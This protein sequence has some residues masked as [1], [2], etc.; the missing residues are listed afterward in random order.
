MRKTLTAT[1]A[2]AAAIPLTFL[3]ATPASAAPGDISAVFT[4][5]PNP[6]GSNTVTGTFTATGDDTIP[7]TCTM[8]DGGAFGAN[9]QYLLIANTYD[10]DSLTR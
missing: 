3:A 10:V 7:Y 8:F 6:G 1:L 5:T 9:G 4:T 2:A